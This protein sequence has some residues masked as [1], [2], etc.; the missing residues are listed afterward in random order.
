MMRRI[1]RLFGVTFD[2]RVS[3]EWLRAN[4]RT[5]AS[6]GVDL[7]CWRSPHEIAEMQ[8]RERVARFVARRS[9]AA[10]RRRA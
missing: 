7:P 9:D 1:A 8:R 10:D 2:K 5:A 3:P 4:E 6:A